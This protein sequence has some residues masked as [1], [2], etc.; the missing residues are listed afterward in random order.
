MLFQ[1]I[2]QL[3]VCFDARSKDDKCFGFNEFV[4]VRFADGASI[5]TLGHYLRGGTDK[6][7]LDVARTWRDAA[8]ERRGQ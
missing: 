4:V 7:F 1:G 5:T 3:V 6:Q 8:T 2:D